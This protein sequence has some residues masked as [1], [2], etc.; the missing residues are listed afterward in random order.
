MRLERVITHKTTSM[1]I[2]SCGIYIGRNICRNK[3]QNVYKI[4]VSSTYKRYRR[5]HDINKL[6]CN[7]L[8]HCMIV[9]MIQR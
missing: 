2:A 7:L 8:Q 9:Y 5:R 6:A 1:F 3:L 4:C